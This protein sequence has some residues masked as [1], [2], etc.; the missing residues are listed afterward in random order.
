MIKSSAVNPSTSKFWVLSFTAFWIWVLLSSFA[1]SLAFGSSSS[2]IRCII[3][4]TSD[5][6]G[7]SVLGET[8]G[9]PSWVYLYSADL[10]ARKA[11]TFTAVSLFSL[12]G[13]T[14]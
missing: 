13:D 1:Y 4:G 14:A 2:A 10:A 7:L 12:A 3:T 5:A 11:A 6:I 9:L 8:I